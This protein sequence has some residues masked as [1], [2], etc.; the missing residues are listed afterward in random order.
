MLGSKAGLEDLMYVKSWDG[1]KQ[2]I[3]ENWDIVVDAA[4]GRLGEMLTVE[5]LE[6]L[7]ASEGGN[8]TEKRKGRQVA[9]RDKPKDGENVSRSSGAG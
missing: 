5:E 2:W 1:L 9:P 6:K 4:V 8:A 7:M 3:V